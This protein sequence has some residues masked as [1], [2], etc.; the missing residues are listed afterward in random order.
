MS[1][2]R[3]GEPLHS[4]VEYMVPP[5][6]CGECYDDLTDEEVDSYDVL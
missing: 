2:H 5:M 4:P 3:C 6:L 1:C